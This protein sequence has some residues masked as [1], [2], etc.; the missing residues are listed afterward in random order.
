MLDD[1]D[2]AGLKVVLTPLSLPLLRW[3]QHNG[4]K[5]DP[6]LWQSFDNH[7]PARHFWSDLATALKG[8][9][10]LAAYNLINEPVP[11]YGAGMAEHASAEAMRQWYTGVQDGPRD[12]RR[13]YWN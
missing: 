4:D 12:L 8:H 10:A 11:E 3:K 9:P 13:F 2:A 7:A 5:V 1:A 6:R